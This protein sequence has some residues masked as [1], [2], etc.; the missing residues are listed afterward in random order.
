L[1]I[2]IIGNKQLV[3]KMKTNLTASKTVLKEKAVDV[4]SLM[5]KLEVDQENADQV[6]ITV[7]YSL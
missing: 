7:L 6:E 5:E 2:Q 1:L 4:E 3:D